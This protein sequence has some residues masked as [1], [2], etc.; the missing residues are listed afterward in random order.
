MWINDH[1]ASYQGAMRRFLRERECECVRASENLRRYLESPGRLKFLSVYIHIPQGCASSFDRID[2]LV[3]GEPDEAFYILLPY[4][5]KN[6]MEL[7]T[8]LRLGGSVHKIA[9][10]E[11]DVK[12]LVSAVGEENWHRQSCMLMR[13]RGPDIPFGKLEDGI[14]PRCALPVT[15]REAA[16]GDFDALLSLHMAYELEELNLESTQAEV[17]PRVQLLL[18]RRIVAVALYDGEP[19]GKINT[20]ARGYFYDQ[21]G[22]FYVKPE[23]RSSG[24]GGVLFSYL[25]HKIATERRSPVLFVRH[26][27][28]PAIKVYRRAGFQPAGEYAMSTMSSTRR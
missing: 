5:P 7:A 4:S 28:I 9:G 14:A 16:G 20:N 8:R 15:V 17:A 23:Y 3:I 12:R 6:D 18:D 26:E 1:I 24:I 13:A 10:M 2:G 22:G 25:L 21:I 19:V 27:N 11:Q